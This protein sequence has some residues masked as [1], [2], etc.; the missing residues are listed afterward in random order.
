MTSRALRAS[1]AASLLSGKGAVTE[2]LPLLQAPFSLSPQLFEL[3]EE[4]F[5]PLSDSL[6]STLAVQDVTQP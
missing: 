4:A 6:Y 1:C 5:L 3:C 2:L